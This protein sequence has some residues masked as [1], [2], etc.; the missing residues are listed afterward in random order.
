MVEIKQ[1]AQHQANLFLLYV[2]S[3]AVMRGDKS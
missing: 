1:A 3:M 2:L